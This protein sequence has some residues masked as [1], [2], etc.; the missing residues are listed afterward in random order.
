MTAI[1]EVLDLFEQRGGEAYF[2]E[3]ISILE[4]SL[5]T[6]WLAEQA[7]AEPHLMV[8]ALLHD[9]GHLLHRMPE[10]IAELGVDA[11]HEA[12][13][14]AWLRSR[15][16]PDVSEPV[17]LHVD[18]KRYL[19]SIQP[20]YL[21]HLSLSSL[22][23]LRLQGGPFSAQEAREFER[24]QHFRDAIALRCWDD[25]AKSPD[26]ELAQ[27]FRSRNRELTQVMTAALAQVLRS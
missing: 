25:A 19:C 1:D 18:A 13:G 16:G 17:R 24:N 21:A 6:A 2:G 7:G 27:Q 14:E 10:D 5:Q 9:I 23:S 11:R 12:I 8:A 20:A 4:H 15:F 26:L 3:D 22:R